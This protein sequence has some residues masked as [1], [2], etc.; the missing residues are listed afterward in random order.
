MGL[1]VLSARWLVQF[2]DEVDIPVI[3]VQRQ[4]LGSR[5]CSA[6]FGYLQIQ[7]LD[8]VAVSVLWR[9]VRHIRH[10]SQH[11]FSSWSSSVGS[12]SSGSVLCGA[13]AVVLSRVS[14]CLTS[15]L[16]TVRPS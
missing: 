12:R 13:C 15:L 2:L 9:F 1:V 11:C 16:L 5:Q 4:V 7:F 8:K 14:C 3:V 6:L 10:D